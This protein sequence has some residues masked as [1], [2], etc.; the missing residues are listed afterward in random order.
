MRFQTNFVSSHY[1]FSFPFL[2]FHHIKF[3]ETV[4][5]TNTTMHYCHCSSPC[6]C[7]YHC[8]CHLG[9]IVANVVALVIAIVFVIAIVMA[10]AIIIAMVVVIVIAIGKGCSH[11]DDH[12]SHQMNHNY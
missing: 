9:I 10:L 4:T 1:P 3:M 5:G 8:P 12:E 2:N 6:C 7:H 11:N